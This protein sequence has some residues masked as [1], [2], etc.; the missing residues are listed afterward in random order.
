MCKKLTNFYSSP[1]VSRNPCSDE[2]PGERAFSE[3]ET[4]SWSELVTDVNH[5]RPI[6]AYFTLH[7]YGQMWMYPYGYT[8]TLPVNHEELDRLSRVGVA[9]IAEVNGEPYETGTISKVIY[10][11]S[12]DSIDW[13]H[14]QLNV[15]VAF[16]IEL[17]D[18][19]HGSKFGIL[20]PPEFIEPT[21]TELWAGL[22]AVLNEL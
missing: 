4:R 7:S 1:G 2:Y 20:L 16:A 11:T 17:R 13:V 9:A 19:R 3:P 6:A 21:A 12:G 18:R 22:R 5:R 14:D 10:K 15:S 8:D